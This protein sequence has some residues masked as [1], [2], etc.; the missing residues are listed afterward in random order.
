LT[1]NV[2]FGLLAA[3]PRPPEL[4][5]P[6]LDELEL[7]PHAASKSAAAITAIVAGAKRLARAPGL[8]LDFIGPASVVR[9]IGP[10]SLVRFIGGA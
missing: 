9:V 8:L 3:L 5:E 7:D 1:I 10:P 2:A 6:E 4:G